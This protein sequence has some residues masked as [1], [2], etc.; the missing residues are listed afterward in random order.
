MAMLSAMPI[1]QERILGTH[2]DTHL[3]FDYVF[4]S[5]T[6]QLDPIPAY[7]SMKSYENSLTMILHGDTN[8]MEGNHRQSGSKHFSRRIRYHVNAEWSEYDLKPMFRE[9][10]LTLM[11]LWDWGM[12]DIQER[13]DRGLADKIQAILYPSN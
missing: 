3:P 11:G 7:E 10:L 4:K 5:I 13:F 2:I 8:L 9:K 1:L 12:D 6:V